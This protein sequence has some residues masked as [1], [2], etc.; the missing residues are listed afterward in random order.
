[1]TEL[2]EKR[3]NEKKERW[4][5]AG[6]HIGESE[7]YLWGGDQPSVGGMTNGAQVDEV[8]K[9]VEG[10]DVNSSEEPVIVEVCQGPPAGTNDG[11]E[12]VKVAA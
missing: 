10:L 3:R 11:T 1:L 4:E 9:A 6:K 8:S 2:A 12:Q 7:I 5:R